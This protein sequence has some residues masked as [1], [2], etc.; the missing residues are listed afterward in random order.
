MQSSARD[1]QF[2]ATDAAH[3]LKP[4][5]QDNL[6]DTATT[7]GWPA[8][9]IASLTV[10]FDGENLSVKYPEELSSEIDDLEY[11]KPFGLPNPVIRPFVYGSEPY[12]R[13]VLVCRTLD[14]ILD[15]EE[16]F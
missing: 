13:E 8:N 10:D 1:L 14:L 12:I 7:A 11:G 4:V 16:V 2:A 5:L 9:I 6:I 15:A 3:F